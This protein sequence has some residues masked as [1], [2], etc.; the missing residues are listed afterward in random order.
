MPLSRSAILAL[1]QKVRRELDALE[2]V[3]KETPATKPTSPAPPASQHNHRPPQPAPPRVHAPR[4]QH[5]RRSTRAPQQAARGGPVTTKVA[6]EACRDFCWENCPCS[7][8]LQRRVA[9][10]SP[11]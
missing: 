2:R 10:T 6:C 5:P 7:C 4:S 9:V 3:V 8:H 11:R 1:I